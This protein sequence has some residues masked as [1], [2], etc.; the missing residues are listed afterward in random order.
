M[1]EQQTALEE[2]HRLAEHIRSYGVKV[3]IELQPGVGPSSWWSPSKIAETSHH[4]VS[5]RSMGLT[6]VLALCKRGRVDVPGPLCNGYGGYDEVYRIITMGWA[7]H[8]GLGGPLWVPA[9]IIPRNNGRPYLWGT[10]YEGGLDPADFSASYR[11]FMARSNAGI[12][13]YLGQPVEAHI[14]HATWTPR[15]IDRLGYTAAIGRAEIRAVMQAARQDAGLTPHQ[16]EEDMIALIEL[17]YRHY[18]DRQAAPQDVLW[19]SDRAAHD[20]LNAEQLHVLFRESKAEKGTV[21]RAYVIYLKREPQPHEVEQWSDGETIEQVFAGVI[22]SKEAQE[23]K[24]Q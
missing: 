3:S 23:K 22:A 7:N 2:A 16:Q 8:P 9:G 18:L 6:P 1:S 19:W 14:E 15:K 4:T 24:G 11:E 17:L 5:R 10:E 12:L 20:N 21:R 13:D